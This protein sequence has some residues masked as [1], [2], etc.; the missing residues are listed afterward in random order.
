[1]AESTSTGSADWIPW[2]DYILGYASNHYYDH[3]PA[4]NPATWH[5]QVGGIMQGDS[6]AKSV[7]FTHVFEEAGLKKISQ[8]AAS[9]ETD[10]FGVP[11]KDYTVINVVDC[12]TTMGDVKVLTGKCKKKPTRMLYAANGDK[13]CIVALVDIVNCERGVAGIALNAFAY[14]VSMAVDSGAG[15]F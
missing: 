12:T 2:V 11:P 7:D 9:M 1:M 10:I 8:A 5:I 6:W 13:T 3:A 14:G 15:G 4:T